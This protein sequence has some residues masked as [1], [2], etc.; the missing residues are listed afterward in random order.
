[1]I[2]LYKR[3]RSTC[4]NIMISIV[5]L[6]QESK[7]QIQLIFTNIRVAEQRAIVA[8]YLFNFIFYL[9]TLVRIS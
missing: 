2:I 3:I 5:Y 7:M 4:R 9:K 6:V 1:M 8:P